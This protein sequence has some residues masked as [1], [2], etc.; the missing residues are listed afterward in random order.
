MDLNHLV[1]FQA[2][3]QTQSFSRAAV[4]LGMDKSRVSRVVGMLEAALGTV[5]LVRTTRSVRLTPDGESLSLRAG[6]LLAALQQAT[7]TLPDRQTLPSGQVVITTT[8]DVGRCILAPLLPQFRAR[9]PAVHVRILVGDQMVDL[10]AEGVDLA[11]RVGRPGRGGCVARRLRHL[12]AA[13]FAAPD[14]LRRHGTPR[15]LAD[16]RQHEGL[17]PTPPKGQRSFSNGKPG[18]ATPPPAVMCSDFAVLA[19]V[20]SAGGGVALLPTF[21]AQPDVDQGRLVRILPE[22]SLGNAPLYLVS[23]QQRPLPP[24]VA[25][26]RNFILEALGA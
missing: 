6:P 1:V 4:H 18:A 24:R 23:R 2:V 20:A 25:C 17:W 26:M 3:A 14:W 19:M 10:L 21:L 11:L 9:F 8:A 22:V 12:E 13:F 15:T 5:L 7:A 16:L